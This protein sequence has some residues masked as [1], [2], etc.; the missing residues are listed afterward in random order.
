MLPCSNDYIVE[1]LTDAIGV[2]VKH[3]G[4][5]RARLNAAFTTFHTLQAEDFPPPLQEKFRNVVQSMRKAG[6]LVRC[7]GEIVRSDVENT[8]RRIRNRTASNLIGEI[9]D[10]YWAVSSNQ[11]YR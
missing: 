1:K 5:A 6:P 3:P 4:D 11:R 8:M 7:D 2:L 10:I 9:Y